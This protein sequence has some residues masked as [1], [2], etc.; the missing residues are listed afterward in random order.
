[1]HHLISAS[2]LSGKM[3]SFFYN[4]TTFGQ[5]IGK[6]NS[7]NKMQT[8]FVFFH[9]NLDELILH[10]KK[11]KRMQ[12]S[13]KRQYTACSLLTTNGIV[14]TSNVWT[15]SSPSSISVSSTKTKMLPVWPKDTCHLCIEQ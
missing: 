3:H 11:K 8:A 6:V 2:H 12:L 1:M 7:I 4:K 9:L 14:H 13:L 5:C 15:G 10:A